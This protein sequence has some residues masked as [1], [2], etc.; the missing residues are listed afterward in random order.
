MVRGNLG[1]KD[2]L[3]QNIHVR[4]ICGLHSSHSYSRKV[5]TYDGLYEVVRYWAE[6]GL[7]GFTIFKF[8]LRQLEGQPVLTTYQVCFIRAKLPMSPSE[9]P[10]LASKDISNG[11]EKLHVPATNVIHK[12]AIPPTG[13]TY[14]NIVKVAKGV[15]IPP[16]IEGCN[17]KGE[18]VNPRT[19]SCARLHGMDF[20][21]V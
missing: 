17:C 13:Y 11:K 5:Y 15:E 4:V 6:R 7:S 2:N 18:C 1:L 8:C 21:Y 10:G 12:P 3:D 9:L 16:P 19:C 14:L 20:M